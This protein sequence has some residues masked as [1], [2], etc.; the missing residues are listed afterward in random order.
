MISNENV[1]RTPQPTDEL[2]SR[3]MKAN[4]GKDTAPEIMLRKALYS[5]GLTGYRLHL[6]KIP[7][8]P[9]I[10]YPGKKIAIFVN[11]CFW[12]R[13]PFCKPELPKSNTDFWASKFRANKKRDERK[14][15]LL[16][17]MGWN[18]LVIWECEIES[19]VL[20]CVDKIRKMVRSS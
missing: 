6:K 1:R 19:D 8:T 17:E 20:W 12:H 7:G 4:R 18:V 14:E 13:C 10:V 15:S 11:G 9:D 2:R 16:V 5:N 3:I